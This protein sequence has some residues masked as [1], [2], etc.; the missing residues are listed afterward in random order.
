MASYTTSAPHLSSLATFSSIPVAAHLTFSAN[1]LSLNTSTQIG[2]QKLL[3]SSLSKAAHNS[4][5]SCQPMASNCPYLHACLLQPTTLPFLAPLHIDGKPLVAPSSPGCPRF[6]NWQHLYTSRVLTLWPHETSHASHLSTSA[7]DHDVLH[8]MKAPGLLLYTK[9]PLAAHESHTNAHAVL[10]MTCKLRPSRPPPQA[11]KRIAKF[12][13]SNIL[14]GGI[15]E[16]GLLCCNIVSA[17]PKETC[18][19]LLVPILESLIASFSDTPKTG[20]GGNDDELAVVDFKVG[21][22][23]ALE[24]TTR[25]YLG[26]LSKAVF[27]GGA[28][29]SAYKVSLQ[30]VIAASFNAPSSKIN[31]AGCNL[32]TAAIGSMVLFYPSNIYEY[33]LNTSIP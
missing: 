6:L 1:R 21:L 24:M 22:S 28:A 14:P 7:P 23:P 26:V 15:E 30:Q 3:I 8:F 29:L 11:L 19:H 12:V 13:M 20:F 18:D 10:F 5:G 2:L 31:D 33:D 9:E 27:Y 25:Y 32:L 17:N 4:Y 16:V